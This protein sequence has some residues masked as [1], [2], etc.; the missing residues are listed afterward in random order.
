MNHICKLHKALYRLTR[1]PLWWFSTLVPVMKRLQ[2]QP[3]DSDVCL[4]KNTALNAIIIIYVDDLLISAPTTQIIQNIIQNLQKNFQ[5]K[6]LGQVQRFLGYTII[7]DR[8]KRMI[9]ISQ[10][11]FTKKIIQKYGYGDLHGVQSPWPSKFILPHRW[12]PIVDK[13]KW[14]LKRTGSLNWLASGTRPDI[15]Y[16]VN[17]LAKA[18]N[19]P[20]NNHITLLKH[21][22]RY[23]I[24]TSDFSLSYG[25]KP[26]L[27]TLFCYSDAAHADD[28][29][30]RFSTAGTIV[31]FAGA[32][33]YWK[34]KKQTLVALSSTEAEFMNLTPAGLAVL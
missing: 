19:G 9:T 27:N 4:F 28:L 14:Y 11:E 23:L 34:S 29:S 21:M 2:F 26:S 1:S 22:F 12:D 3:F 20:S 7:H 13:K 25:G 15:T 31:F 32:P 5:L 6:V 10:V 8:S 30:T 24:Q 18:N 17:R 33:V 16:T